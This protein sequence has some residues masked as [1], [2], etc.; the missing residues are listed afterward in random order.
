ME[1][2]EGRIMEAFKKMKEGREERDRRQEEWWDEECKDKKR[3]VRR[4]L[5]DWR[6]EGGEG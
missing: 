6:K 3:K 4:E 1:E 2:M 5:R